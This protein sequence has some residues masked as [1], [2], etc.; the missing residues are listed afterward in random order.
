VTPV[1]RPGPLRWLWYAFGGRL[2]IRY[3]QWV[4]RDVTAGWWR[5]RS[6]L[7]ALVQ[8]A[9]VAVLIYVLVP[10]EPW[11]RLTAILGG[12]LVGMMY[13]TAYLDEV[14]ETRALKAGFLRGVAQQVRDERL[15]ARPPGR[16]AR[17]TQPYRRDEPPHPPTSSA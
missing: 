6:L 2:P 13:A 10:A 9:P 16:I 5:L 11:V 1:N 14:A 8:I 12:T 7:R 3:S 15:A 17:F 4:L